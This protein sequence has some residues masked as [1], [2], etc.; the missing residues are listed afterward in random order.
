MNIRVKTEKW[1]GAPGILCL[2]QYP[3]SQ[4]AEKGII[5]SSSDPVNALETMN[6]SLV[7]YF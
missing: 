1:I 6:K 2:R 4:L 5:P 3:T 7:D